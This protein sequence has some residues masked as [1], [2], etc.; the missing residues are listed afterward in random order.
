MPFARP[1]LDDLDAQAAA[2]LAAALPGTDPLLSVANLRILA[3][4]Q[5]EGFNAEYGYLDYIAKQSVPFTAVDEAFE[6]WAALKGVTRKPATAAVG[7]GTWPGAPGSVLPTGTPVSRGDGQAYET[8]EDA[9]VTG[10]GFVTAPIVALTLG[11]AAT[12][13]TGSV[14][15]VGVA[16]SGISSNGTATAV[17]PGVDV[18][19]SDAFRTRTLAIYAAP[20]QGGSNPDYVEW[21]EQVPGVTRAWC[22]PHGKGPGTV[23]VYFMMDLAEAAHDGFPQG[24][25]GCASSE[26]RDAAAIGDPLLVANWIY[27]LQPV[28]ALV[29]A[30]APLKNTVAFTISLAGAS[31]ALKAAVDVAI[32]EVFLA[33][34]SPGGA[35]LP[36]GTTGGVLQLSRIEGAIAALPGAK[37]FVITAVASDHGVVTPGASGNVASN[38]GYLPVPGVTTWP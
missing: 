37:G 11:S 33:D 1:T 23:I 9:V 32:A 8:T 24:T 17:T 3:K 38:P 18:E 35:I 6:G 5:A 15:A 20:P 4:I 19:D 22:V 21:A 28:T 29:Y 7:A 27:P 31:A 14:L 13:A 12:L 30:L 25:G 36:D 34:G 2:D 16:V 10:G 26:T